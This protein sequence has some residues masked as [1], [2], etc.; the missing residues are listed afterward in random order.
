MRQSGDPVNDPDDAERAFNARSTLDTLQE[1]RRLVRRG[2]RPPQGDSL[3]QR[4]D[5][6]RH[7]R[8]HLRAPARLITARRRSSTRRATRSPPRRVSNVGDLRHRP[9][10]PDRTSATRRS[11]SSRSPTTRRSASARAR[12]RTSCGCRRTACGRCRRKPAASRSSTGTTSP[13]P[14]SASSQDNS[15]YYVLAYYPP[16]AQAG[17]RTQDRRPCLA[18][19]HVVR[20]RRGH[21]TPKKADAVEA[22]S[23]T[24]TRDARGEGG[25]RQPA[26]GQRP[27]DARVR[28]AVQGHGAECVGAVRRRDAR[29]RPAV[30]TPERP[31]CSCPI[32]R[33][34]AK[35]RC[36]AAI[37][38]ADD[39]EPASGNQDAHRAVRPADAEPAGSPARPLPVPRRRARLGRRQVGSVCWTSTCRTS[40]RRRSASAGWR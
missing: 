9:A 38:T 13:R 10:R 4:R 17:A 23:A 27:D 19:E 3:R 36:A 35:A 34:D 30:S 25:A 11:R 20:A 21:V 6:L 1:R 7:P 40:S 37:P 29:P 33:I 24:D 18:A 8:H 12:C 28:G 26:A 5:R 14:I 2:P 16:D 15:S 22:P 31:S 39:G 32:S